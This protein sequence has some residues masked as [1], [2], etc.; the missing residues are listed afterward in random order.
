MT[1]FLLM[2]FF[3]PTLELS[4]DN[5]PC[6]PVYAY[7][8]MNLYKH[9]SFQ[10]KFTRYFYPL[11]FKIFKTANISIVLFGYKFIFRR[12]SQTSSEEIIQLLFLPQYHSILINIFLFC[13]EY[14]RNQQLSCALSVRLVC[15]RRLLDGSEDTVLQCYHPLAVPE[16]L[17]L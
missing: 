14:V 9:P 15:G 7:S 12:S 8:P 13:V 6:F 5:N 3:P 4:I 1:S 2:L 17:D 11:L 16:A 10:R